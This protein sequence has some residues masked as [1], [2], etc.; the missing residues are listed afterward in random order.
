[1]FTGT[2]SPGFLSVGVEFLH[3]GLTKSQRNASVIHRS[4]MEVGKCE[5]ALN[6]AG[7]QQRLALLSVWAL[8]VDTD[9]LL[10]G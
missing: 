3:E 7:L 1:M 6:T 2:V 9:N 4:N 8:V 5:C 10:S